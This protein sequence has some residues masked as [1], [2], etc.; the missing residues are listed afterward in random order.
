[1]THI[2]LNL[3][4]ILMSLGGKLQAYAVRRKLAEGMPEPLMK[5]AKR[6]PGR[7]RGPRKPK[8]ASKLGTTQTIAAPTETNPE[9]V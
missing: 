1:M 2:L 6:K 8:D 3:S 9:R 7:P 4:M 5:P